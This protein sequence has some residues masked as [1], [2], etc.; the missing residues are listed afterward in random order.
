MKSKLLIAVGV[1]LCTGVFAGGIKDPVTGFAIVNKAGTSTYKLFY[2]NSE[3]QNVKV[4]IL[5][6]NGKTVFSE[7]ISNV[8]GFVRPYN[9]SELGEGEYTMQIEDHSGIRKEQV[10]YHAEKSGDL[11]NV[12]KLVGANKYLVTS[13]SK[14]N[15]TVAIK[16][17]NENGDILYNDSSNL[18]EAFARVYRLEKISGTITFKITDT[19]GA[20][21]VLTF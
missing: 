10:S 15:A 9:F 13:P 11:F 20:S 2:T 6:T 3:S 19:T 5:D 21:K 8:E 12:I 16:I 7:K 18:D 1:L 14:E 17:Y 4:S